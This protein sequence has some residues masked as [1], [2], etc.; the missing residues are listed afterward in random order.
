M[1]TTVRLGK[2]LVAHVPIKQLC[3]AHKSHSRDRALV[4]SREYVLHEGLMRA[5][6]WYGSGGLDQINLDQV[7]VHAARP[8]LR[9]RACLD[10]VVIS[11]L[12]LNH[13][14]WPMRCLAG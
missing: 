7:T 6:V 13:I 2:G 11:E 1:C 9:H 8:R 4:L 5:D 3:A 10:A 12:I 14:A